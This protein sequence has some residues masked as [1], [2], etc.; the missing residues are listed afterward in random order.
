MI[1]LRDGE[2]ARHKERVRNETRMVTFQAKG[3]A[4]A[5]HRG[6]CGDPWVVCLEYR[7]QGPGM[8]GDGMEMWC[9]ETLQGLLIPPDRVAWIFSCKHWVFLKG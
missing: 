9:V 6:R 7:T 3:R 8:A 1:L 2:S 4:C 5:E